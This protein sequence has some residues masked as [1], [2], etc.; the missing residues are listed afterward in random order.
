M[1][2]KI[3][4]VIG[5]QGFR[6]Q[7]TYYD[8]FQTNE[9]TRPWLASVPSKYFIDEDGHKWK[10][11][12]ETA[13]FVRIDVAVAYGLKSVLQGNK[14]IQFDII[15]ASELTGKRVESYNLVINQFF[16]GLVVPFLKRFEGS[17]G[18]PQTRLMKIYE[19]HADRMYPPM[20]YHKLIMNKCEYYNF[21]ADIGE[22]VLPTLCIHRGENVVAFVQEKLVPFLKAN[23]ITQLFTKPVHGTDSKDIQLFTDTRRNTFKEDFVKHVRKVLSNKQYPGIVLQK[24]AKDFETKKP[25]ARMY[26]VGDKYMYTVLTKRINK[27]DTATYLYHSTRDQEIPFDQLKQRAQKIIRAFRTRYFGNTPT[28]LTRVDFGCCLNENTFFVN[29]IEFNGGNYVHMDPKPGRRFMYDKHMIDQLV[30]VI[31]SK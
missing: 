20:D 31:E 19:K 29:E 13:P 22:S 14:D 10:P 24:F 30:K 28:F 2:K 6:W 26:F 5:P 18:T 16:D 8:K 3:G 17:N 25:Q 1:V 11:N 4:F 21:L 7:D 12:S 27:N 23:K 9:K 15:P